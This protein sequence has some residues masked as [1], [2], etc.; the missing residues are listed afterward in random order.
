M[1][2][3]ALSTPASTTPSRLGA[4]PDRA[5][6]R[7]WP[8]HRI[9]FLLAG[10]FTLTGTILA[11]SVNRWFALLPGLVGANQLLL[12]TTGWCPASA[13][14]DRVLPAASDP[15]SDGRQPH[16]AR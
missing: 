7:H 6:G 10:T 8:K 15:G 16:C 13:L 12:V 1:T 4:A 14:L 11:A 3:P 2:T 5:A 9:L